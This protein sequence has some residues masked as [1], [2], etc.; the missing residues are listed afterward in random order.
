MRFAVVDN[1]ATCTL[2]IYV[3]DGGSP[4]RILRPANFPT[5]PVWEQVAEGVEVEASLRIPRAGPEDVAALI[6]ALQ[7]AVRLPVPN[8]TAEAEVLRDTLA[9]ERLRVDRLLDC[10]PAL[11]LR[12]VLP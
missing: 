9:V 12:G 7:Q 4:E 11:V 6:A 3:F 5:F 10:L 8:A 2:D 1:F